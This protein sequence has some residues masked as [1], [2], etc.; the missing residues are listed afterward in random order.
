MN[1]LLNKKTAERIIVAKRPLT[2]DSFFEI[3][4][5][6][7]SSRKEIDTNW[8]SFCQEKEVDFFGKKKRVRVSR[9][10]ASEITIRHGKLETTIFLNDDEEVYQST[11]SQTTFYPGGMKQD[12]ILGRIVGIVKNDKVIEERFLSSTTNEILGIRV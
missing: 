12:R 4:F 5:A 1:G 8:S 3:K 2:A 10:K 9:F 6:D 7:G 11:L